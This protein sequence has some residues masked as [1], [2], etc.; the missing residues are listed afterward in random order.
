[1]TEVYLFLEILLALYSLAQFANGKLKAVELPVLMAVTFAVWV[2]PQFIALYLSKE[3]PHQM[4]DKALLMSLLC[5]GAAYLGY[6]WPRRSFNF[7]EMSLSRARLEQGVFVLF[8]FAGSFYVLLNCLPVEMLEE[9]QWVGLPVVYLFLAKNL[10]V[11]AMIALFLSQD[12]SAKF[13]WK[14]K[15][16]LTGGSIYYFSFIFLMGRRAETLE[17]ILLVLCMLWFRRR[18]Q[19]SRIVIVSAGVVFMFFFSAIAQYRAA[20]VRFS[21]ERRQWSDVLDIDFIKSF[22]ELLMTSGGGEMKNCAVLIDAIDRHSSFDFGFSIYNDLIQNFVPRQ[23]VGQRVKQALSIEFESALDLA[24]RDS[25]FTPWNGT[26][27]GGMTDAFGSFWYFGC[28]EF[29][30][31]GWF[32]R[33]LY[34]GSMRGWFSSQVAYALFL[35]PALHS[36]THSTFYIVT[37]IIHVTLF[38]G[39]VVWY[40]RKKYADLNEGSLVVTR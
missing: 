3:I 15:L 6:R 23:F 27:L 9:S 4:L 25:G 40:A 35:T 31:I 30:L 28:F 39:P 18:I 29:F 11:C 26:S 12:K 13:S 5:L 8:L 17:A 37:E 19:P 36:I 14:M 10:G 16:V 38:M 7:F 33:K 21:G 2:L 34:L 1:M 24:Y 20:V 32:M 22:R